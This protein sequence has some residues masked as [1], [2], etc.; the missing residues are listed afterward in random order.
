MV[1]VIFKLHHGG[2]MEPLALHD[3]VT[4]I[5]IDQTIRHQTS[6]NFITVVAEEKIDYSP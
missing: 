4:R 5:G 6:V 2:L 1:Q 3:N